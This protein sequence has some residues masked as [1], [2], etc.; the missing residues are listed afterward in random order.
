MSKSN[1]NIRI[2]NKNR[3]KNN[4]NKGHIDEQTE[5]IFK[6]EFSFVDKGSLISRIG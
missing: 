1:K 3:G 5:T 6:E 2:N 4:N